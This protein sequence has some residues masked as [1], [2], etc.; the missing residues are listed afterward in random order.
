MLITD[1]HRK[2]IYYLQQGM[3]ACPA[4]KEAGFAYDYGT[5]LLRKLSKTV[6]FQELMDEFGLSDA[7]LLLNHKRLLR[8]KTIKWNPET[9]KWDE[10]DAGDTQ[11][12]ALDLGY[13][14]KG[15]LKDKLDI[16]GSIEVVKVLRDQA[17]DIV[18]GLDKP[19]KDV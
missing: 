15:K 6:E 8:A 11:M 19:E 2:F 1:K 10:F 7:E 14:L 18:D 3:D 16:S 5:T 12:K 13:K 17:E 9:R 4:A